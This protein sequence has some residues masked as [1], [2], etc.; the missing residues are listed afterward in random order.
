MF[1]TTVFEVPQH[2]SI[3]E[4]L[5]IERFRDRYGITVISITKLDNGNF[6]VVLDIDNPE[7]YNLTEFI[8]FYKVNMYGLR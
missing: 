4:A 8:E 2:P 3:N 5:M 7:D 1:T 6:V